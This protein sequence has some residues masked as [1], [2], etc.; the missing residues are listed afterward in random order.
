MLLIPIELGKADFQSEISLQSL[1]LSGIILGGVKIIYSQ[2][3]L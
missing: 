3:K 1:E 2:S